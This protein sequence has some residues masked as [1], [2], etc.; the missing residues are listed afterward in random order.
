MDSD[1]LRQFADPCSCFS[2]RKIFFWFLF[3]LGR[4]G[5][6]RWFVWGKWS[7]IR[8]PLQ[9]LCLLVSTARCSGRT[10]FLCRICPSVRCLLVCSSGSGAKQRITL[11]AIL[12]VCCSSAVRGIGGREGAKPDLI[13]PVMRQSWSLSARHASL[14]LQCNVCKAGSRLQCALDHPRG[15]VRGPGWG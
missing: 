10:S 12:L 7:K 1:Y 4:D 5:S 13:C 11:A 6:G 9:L 14:L 3:H 15:V 8:S 2:R